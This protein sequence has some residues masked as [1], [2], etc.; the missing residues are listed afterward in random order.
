MLK[1]TLLLLPILFAANAIA[2]NDLPTSRSVGKLA[3]DIS[4]DLQRSVKLQSIIAPTSVAEYKPRGLAEVKEISGVANRHDQY[5]Y[6]YDADLSSNF[7][8]DNDGFYHS[9]TVSFDVDVTVDEAAIYAK[10][11]LSHEGGPWIPYYTTDLFNIYEDSAFDR[12]EVTTDLVDGYPTGYY[13][14]LI[15]V[16]SLNHAYQV[17]SEVL[18]YSYLG[19][20]TLLE[21]FSRDEPLDY[22]YYDEY[23]EVSYSH[24]AGNTGFTLILIL[25]LI[26]VTI[27]A[28]R[29]FTLTPRKT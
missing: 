25:I 3:M 10:L 27:V 21:D 7:D 19:R 8:D 17:A 2:A 13:D 22:Y 1:N 16:F 20:E 5:F 12:Y 14:V 26:Q 28:R 23:E 9:L 4:V 6:I 15:E 29:S 24:G 18:D 11:Y